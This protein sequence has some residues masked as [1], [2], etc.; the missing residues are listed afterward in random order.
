MVKSGDILKRLY[1]HQKRTNKKN[2]GGCASLALVLSFRDDIET[3]LENGYSVMAIHSLLKAEGKVAI[4]Y[5]SFLKALKRGNIIPDPA[6]KMACPDSPE[7]VA[8]QN[9][10]YTTPVPAIGPAVS[11]TSKG[12]RKPVIV[13]PVPLVTEMS[14]TP[15][16]KNKI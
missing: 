8:L 10:L 3:A 14:A 15:T 7:A 16:P 1:E 2:K 4:C 11:T 9:D 12:S 13:R 5:Q 6:G